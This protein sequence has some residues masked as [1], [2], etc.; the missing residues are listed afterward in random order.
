MLALN[1]LRKG[2]CYKVVN[3]GDVY[4]FQ[5]IEILL[6]DDFLLKDIHTFEIYKFSLITDYGIGEDYSIDEL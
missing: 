4:E 2:H 6:E 1:S 3:F 5:I